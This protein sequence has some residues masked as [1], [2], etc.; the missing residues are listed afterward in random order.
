[1]RSARQGGFTL[2]EMMIVIAIIG[3]LA[4]IAVT[5]PE[6]DE[7]TVAGSSGQISAELDRI[8]LRSM[9]THRWER[10]VFSGQTASLQEGNTLGMVAP[11]TWTQ[12]S[13]FTIA[14][15]SKVLS[16]SNTS[17]IDPTGAAAATG[18]GLTTGVAFAPDGT[19]T[20]HTIY[21]QD[22]R[23]RTRMR[24]VVFAA[25]GTVLSRDGW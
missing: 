14:D 19:S 25:T 1:M 16:I 10:M 5:A 9:A 23:G 18:T 3:V 4:S 24:L 21:L 22:R 6:E 15:A 12:V 11:T 13:T 2:T 17:A 7:S 8:R 20:A